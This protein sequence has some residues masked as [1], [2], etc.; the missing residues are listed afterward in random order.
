MNWPLSHKSLL[1]YVEEFNLKTLLKRAGSGVRACVTVAVALSSIPSTH[2]GQLT[3]TSTFQKCI[4]KYKLLI[5]VC[6]YV[7]I[8]VCMLCVCVYI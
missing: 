2:D 6:V 4:A 3:T 5:C 7:C 1:T 8:H